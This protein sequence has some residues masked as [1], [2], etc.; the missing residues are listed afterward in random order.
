M[1]T[2]VDA[3][4]RRRHVG[5]A[6]HGN[7]LTALHTL[8][9]LQ[10][11]GR[12]RSG[13]RYIGYAGLGREFGRSRSTAYRAVTLLVLAELIIRDAG[14]AAGPNRGGKTTDEQGNVVPRANGY[15]LHPALHHAAQR[16]PRKGKEA[17][18]Q[19]LGPLGQHAKRLGDEFLERQRDR[20][21]DG[22]AA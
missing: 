5:K 6:A 17:K 18:R 7:A 13:V 20:A 15:Q 22:P 19:A 12:P 10:R 16:Q 4:G 3:R 9:R 14:D 2:Y 21:R 8:A 11:T 1:A